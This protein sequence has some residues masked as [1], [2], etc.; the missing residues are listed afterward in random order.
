MKNTEL[1]IYHTYKTTKKSKE[2]VSV[3]A[4]LNDC[5]ES[6]IQEIVDRLGKEEE[7]NS[8]SKTTRAKA[9]AK[10]SKVVKVADDTSTP[11]TQTTEDVSDI[12][13]EN[14]IQ[15]MTLGTTKKPKKKS[16]TKK[17]ELTIREMLISG[18]DVD[19]VLLEC[20]LPLNDTECRE[21]IKDIRTT[22]I[23]S[24]KIKRK[25]PTA[26]VSSESPFKVA[27]TRNAF[28]PPS[29]KTKEVIAKAKDRAEKAGHKGSLSQ[30]EVI[31]MHE[32]ESVNTTTSQ[33]IDVSSINQGTSL[34]PVTQP[35]KKRGRPKKSQTH[36]TSVSDSVS[37][38]SPKQSTSSE[39]P[40]NTENHTS[41]DEIQDLCK[42]MV[43]YIEQ[44]DKIYEKFNELVAT[45]QQL[46][47]EVI[48]LKKKLAKY[49]RM[50]KHV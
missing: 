3:L 37:A 29:E 20:D 36:E 35:A 38:P 39:T 24:G 14:I 1:E 13:D 47:T 31:K 49:E 41:F 40:A 4:Q 30:Q 46:N 8:S 15:P 9:K 6:T 27:Q 34:E 18:K 23:A 12:K 28:N 2:A 16:I 17:L 32:V 42:D 50:F 5:P 33:Q 7:S 22:L 25:R 10:T 44:T 11:E 26:V 21:K 48:E 45:A 19:T 43:D